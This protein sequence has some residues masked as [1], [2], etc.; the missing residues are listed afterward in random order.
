MDGGFLLSAERREFH[1]RTAINLAL[2]NDR[3]M[4]I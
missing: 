1:S 2:N 3:Q 4:F